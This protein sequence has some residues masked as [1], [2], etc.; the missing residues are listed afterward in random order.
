M[1]ISSTSSPKLSVHETADLLRV[2]ESWLNKARL[3]GS[4]PPF[5]KLGRRVL[6][7]PADIESWL[8]SRKFSSTSAYSSL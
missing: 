8:S 3:I 6:Y 1:A 5:M 7:D 4:G 2:S